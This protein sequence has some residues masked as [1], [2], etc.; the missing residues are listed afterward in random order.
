MDF[1]KVAADIYAL[2]GPAANITQA[3]NCMTRLRVHVHREAFSKEQL[4]SIPGVLGANKVGDEWQ[5]ILG[6][7]KA[8]KVTAAFKVLVETKKTQDTPVPAAASVSDLAKKAAIGDGKALHHAIQ[9]KNATPLKLGLKKIAQIFTPIIPAFIACGLI[10]GILNMVYKLDPTLAALPMVQML[11][12]AG[13][14]VFFGLNIFV[15]INSAKVFGGSPMLGGVMAAIISHPMLSDITFMGAPLWPGRGGIIAVLLVVL[16][17][18]QLE[19]RLHH[20]VPTMIDLFVTPLVTVLVST[21]V[22]LCICQPIGGFLSE[23]IG[24]LATASIESGGAITGIVLGGTFLPMV[25]CGIHQGLTPI[26]AELLGHYG[27]NILLPILAMAGGGQ[28]GA[29]I[30]VYIKTKN[31]RLRTT[32]ASALPVGFMGIGEPLIYGV[33]LPLGK[34]FIGACIGG[35]FG[36]AVQ[37]FFMVGATSMGISGL[38]LAL[39]TNHILMYL[40]GLLTAYLVGFIATWLIGFDDPIDP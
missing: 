32:I 4:Q 34:P 18:S 24:T 37:A 5:I 35:A 15:G 22:A 27:I 16:F 2:V 29:S 28:V 23:V 9:Q 6:P 20:Y 14:A 40:L 12:V 11:A 19:K 1:E 30:A 10:T 25:M 31:S 33:T 38:P 13:N 8:T 3:Y 17:S 26:H 39:C 7:G 21:F 36:G